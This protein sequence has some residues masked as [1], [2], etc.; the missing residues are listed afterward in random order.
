L[1][2]HKRPQV[3][4]RAVQ[5]YRGALLLGAPT[6]TFRLRVTQLETIV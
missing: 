3:I 2:R 1:Q 6:I 5:L 4:L